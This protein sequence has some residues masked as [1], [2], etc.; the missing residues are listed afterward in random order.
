MFDEYYSGLFYGFEQWILLFLVFFSVF[1]YVLVGLVGIIMLLLIIGV[2]FGFG[3]W[4]LY[5][6][7]MLLL[8]LGIGIFLQFN[9]V[10]GIGVGMICMQG[11]SFV[12]FG[13]MVVGGMW[14]K[15]QGGG[16]QD[17]MV[18]LFGVNFVVVLVLV[19]VSCFI[20][21]LKKIFIFIIIGSVIVLIGISLIKVSV[22]NWCGGE[23]VEDFVSMSNIVFGVGIFGVIVL[24]SCVKNCWLWFF[25]VVVGI[26]V[27][28][29]VVGLSGQFY[30]YSL[31]DILFCLLMLFLFG[32]QFNSVIFLLVVLV[33]LVCILEV[34][35]DLMVNLLIL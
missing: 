18:M 30:F 2:I 23:K 31:G 1:Q 19:I 3:D 25:L 6:I 35:G 4:L 7:S 29:I 28:C 15:V 14:V 13:V 17:M 34:V 5:F 33:L 20:E 12:F 21:L 24:L 11:I 16:L 32:F 10:W 9:W 26:V 22:I 27:G 8:V